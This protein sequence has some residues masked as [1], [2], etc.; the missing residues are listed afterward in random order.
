MPHKF[1]EKFL[2]IL[3]CPDCKGTIKNKEETITCI[4]CERTFE[5]CEG[6]II[7]MFP[8]QR[9]KLPDDYF[10][11]EYLKAKKSLIDIINYSHNVNGVS[12]RIHN[13]CHNWQQNYLSQIWK[14]DQ[15]IVDLGCG[16][17]GHWGFMPKNI[18]P[19]LVGIDN[20]LRLLQAAHKSFPNAKLVLGD[21]IRLPFKHE[22]FQHILSINVLEHIYFLR[23]A[24]LEMF[25]VLKTNGRLQVS[26]PTEGGILWSTGRL[27][28]T[29]RY[30]EKK[31]LNYKKLIQ[32]EHCNTAKAVLRELKL[33]FKVCENQYYPF[34]IPTINFN[35]VIN[36]VFKKLKV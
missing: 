18:I 19:H 16:I 35:L 30:F 20:N 10:D 11:P 6:N 3:A 23:D 15:W 31:G 22:S 21:M 5:I 24:V 29:Q 33:Y 26:I 36:S 9:K 14:P 1:D 12:A 17:G 32:L 13:S 25:R 34:G 27:I 28:T 7:N 8:L 2:S 4:K